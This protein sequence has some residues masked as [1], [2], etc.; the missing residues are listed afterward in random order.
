[1]ITT[2]V[3]ELIQQPTFLDLMFIATIVSIATVVGEFLTSAAFLKTLA[4]SVITTAF[5]FALQSLMAP[6]QQSSFGDLGGSGSGGGGSGIKK[7]FKQAITHRMAVY[8]K[9]RIGGPIVFAES[10]G[11]IVDKD[12]GGNV[13]K[14]ENKYLHMVIVHASHPC[15]EITNYYANDVQLNLNSNGVNQEDEFGKFIRIRT[16]LGGF[17]QTADSA[18]VDETDKWTEDHRL[19]GVCYSYVRL[20]WDSETFGKIGIPTITVEMKG[21]NNIFD[22]R[23]NTYK[24]TNN[25]AL[26]TADYLRNDRIGFGTLEGEVSEKSV[27]QSANVCDE[28][29]TNNDDTQEK[30]YALNGVVK[31]NEQHKNV[32]ARMLGTM[33]G[34]LTHTSG[35]FYVRAGAFT[36]CGI[37]FDEDNII[38]SISLSTQLPFNEKINSIRGTYI[39][40]NADYSGVDFAPIQNTGYITEDGEQKWKDMQLRYT[41]SAT[42]AKRLARITLEKARREKSFEAIFDLKAYQLK[43][44]DIIEFSHDRFGWDHK[45]FRVKSWSLE[46]L[47][48]EN[49]EGD[50][51]GVEMKLKETDAGV[52]RNAQE[53]PFEFR[54]EVSLTDPAIAAPPRN[55][56]AENSPV[57]LEDGSLKPRVILTWDQ[58]I[59]AQVASGGRTEVAIKESGEQFYR[60]IRFVDGETEK[61]VLNEDIE[62]GQ[63]YDFRIRS[64]SGERG[65]SSWQ[66]IEDFEATGDEGVS[67][68]VTGLDLNYYG[69]TLEI[70]WN[71]V[72]D[73][74]HDHYEVRA[75]KGDSFDFSES[76][77][78]G[79]E[80]DVTRMVTNFGYLEDNDLTGDD[81]TIGVKAVDQS[82][83]RSEIW[84][85]ATISCMKYQQ[86]ESAERTTRTESSLI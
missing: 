28:I 17:D 15:E 16:H 54:S 29:V 52:Y 23:T 81:I 11:T 25:S 51:H 86:V 24:Y 82:N 35:K 18:L 1:M 58:A 41:T 44:G 3:F 67:K 7:N 27:A 56:N 38:D 78:I 34:T 57:Q 79:H 13:E 77:I 48:P 30:R 5:S 42:R 84:T 43:V 49:G 20:E 22:P 8:G 26:C 76:V 62:P 45:T 32:L 55:F 74:D 6:E 14:K 46:V 9:R 65:I 85:T 31:T 66:V 73:N 19:R 36:N 40:P 2:S 50:G 53:E 71:P 4:A 75:T 64:L 61:V 69:T 33:D 68:D 37:H 72:P 83:N 12:P 63:K 21:K 70:D 80:V 59:D 39:D 47:S 60:S 10:N